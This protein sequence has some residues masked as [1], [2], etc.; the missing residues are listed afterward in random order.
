MKDVCEA[1]LHARPGQPQV[2]ALAIKIKFA[3]AFEPLLSGL[4][5]DS[6]DAEAT[7]S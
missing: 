3:A 2:L 7:S 5:L 6:V 1:S 4:V